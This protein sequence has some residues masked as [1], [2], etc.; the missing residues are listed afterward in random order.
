LF[1]EGNQIA[2]GRRKKRGGKREGGNHQVV[3]TGKLFRSCEKTLLSRNIGQW[4]K[5]M[6]NGQS[7]VAKRKRK[8]PVHIFPRHLKREREKDGRLCGKNKIR[9]GKWR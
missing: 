2:L 6:L 1:A 9:N 3:Q 8:K 7:G 4:V 5:K